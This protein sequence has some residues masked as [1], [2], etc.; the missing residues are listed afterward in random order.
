[1]AS[2]SLVAALVVA[3]LPLYAAAALPFDPA[4]AISRAFQTAGDASREAREGA[5]LNSADGT[6]AA[7]PAPAKPA[8]PPQF[9]C[10]FSL[11]M[12]GF[13]LGNG[14]FQYDVTNAHT[15]MNMTRIQPVV[16]EP[17]DMIIYFNKVQLC[18]RV[19]REGDDMR[20]PMTLTS[21]PV[22]SPFPPPQDR[23]I[24]LAQ[25]QLQARARQPVLQPL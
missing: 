7:A 4:R 5:L 13:D 11:Q 2:R 18:C 9:S 14:S 16:E 19:L 17:I 1:M 12:V 8:F 3:L 24:H 21:T 10:D 25:R 20:S 22:P 6:G 23:R 15:I